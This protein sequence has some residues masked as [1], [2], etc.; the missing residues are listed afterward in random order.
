MKGDKTYFLQPSS[1]LLTLL[2]RDG[3]YILGI[4]GTFG[5]IWVPIGRRSLSK[6]LL[7]LRDDQDQK[8]DLLL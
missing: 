3:D 1:L 2:F 5:F 8:E 4:I 7:N 6:W